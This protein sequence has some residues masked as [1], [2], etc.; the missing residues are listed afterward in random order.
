MDHHRCGTRRGLLQPERLEEGKF[1]PLAL[2]GIDR[3]TARGQAIRL[4]FGNGTEVAGAEKRANLVV[5]VGAI[6]RGVNAKPGK[7][8]IG[9]RY[10]ADI[11]A[12]CKIV[13]PVPDR[14]GSS[15][16]DLVNVD[17]VLI[18]KAAVEKLNLEGQLLAT[19]SR[20]LRQKAN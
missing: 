12:E 17:P 18:E 11:V 7:P 10:L 19:P 4:A 14:Y 3:Q 15:A 5:I 9:V 1:L 20:A 13:A 2:A 6:D 16:G 8:E